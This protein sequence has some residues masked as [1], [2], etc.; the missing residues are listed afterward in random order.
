MADIQI[1]YTSTKSYEIDGVTVVA[2]Y[3]NPHPAIDKVNITFDSYKGRS[4]GSI[5]RVGRLF[6]VGNKAYADFNINKKAY[7]LDIKDGTIYSAVDFSMK[8]GSPLR[9][10]K[11]IKPSD[12]NTLNDLLGH[13]ETFRYQMLGRFKSDCEYFLGFGRGNESRLWTQNVE[14]HI[15]YM[16]AL[17]YS[18]QGK[19]I[20][21]WLTINQIRDYEK[22]MLQ[23]K[24]KR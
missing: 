8:T 7:I 22:A 24:Y 6:K 5:N 1:K 16:K 3:V 2:V 15:Y 17:Y 18:F 23:I 10:T 14:E 11:G 12:D 19:E 9:M 13:D 21:R 20:P 4:G